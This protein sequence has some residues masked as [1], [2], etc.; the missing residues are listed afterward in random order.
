MGMTLKLKTLERGTLSQTF[1]LAWEALVSHFGADQVAGISSSRRQFGAHLLPDLQ[2]AVTAQVDR[3]A[4]TLVGCIKS[5][6]RYP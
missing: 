4:P 3:F 6:R 2:A 5:T 1:S